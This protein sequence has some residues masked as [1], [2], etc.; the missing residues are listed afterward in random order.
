MNAKSIAALAAPLLLSACA[1]TS[2][3]EPQDPLEPV[4]RA[5]YSFNETAD[6]YVL[7]PVARGYVAVTPAFFRT[8]VR[9]F[10]SNLFYPITIVNQYAQ[11]E[12][13]EGSKDV[14]RLLVNTTIGIGGLI[15]VAQYWGMPA[16]DEDFGQTLGTWGVGEGWYLMVPF[17][18]PYT[19]RDFVGM[20]VG[21]PMSPLYYSDDEL[22]LWGLTALD[23]TQVRADLLPADALLQEQSDRYA[24]IRSAY[25]QKR[26]SAVRNGAPP[27]E[28]DFFDDLL[29][30][31]F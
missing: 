22:L 25:L 26:Q 11:G 15:D 9:N 12:F 5:I 29:D 2:V 21:L 20:L 23:K 19:N 30:E 3:Y 6:R 28:D 18:G 4:N 10:F 27:P 14:G 7:K 8:G 24:F 13:I 31:E 16:H 17:L 1:H